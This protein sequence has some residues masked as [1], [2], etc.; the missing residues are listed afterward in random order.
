LDTAADPGNSCALLASLVERLDVGIFAVDRS[1][2]VALWNS[3]MALHSGKSSTDMLGQN[4]FAMFPELPR[5]WLEK[6]AGK[7]LRPWQQRFYPV[8]PAAVSVSLREQPTDYRRPCRDAPE[9][10]FSAPATVWRR[11]VAGLRHA[12]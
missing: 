11:G 7:R 4:L 2:T 6:K 8:G 3:F 10:H 5:P 9:R 12:L 1:G